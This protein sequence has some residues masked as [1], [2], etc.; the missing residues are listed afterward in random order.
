MVDTAA[1]SENI[2]SAPYLRIV[3]EDRYVKLQMRNNSD[4]VVVYDGRDV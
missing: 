1:Y 4:N 2:Q 3:D